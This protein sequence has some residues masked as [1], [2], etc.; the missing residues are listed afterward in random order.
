MKSLP[1]LLIFLL[2]AASPI[3]SGAPKEPALI[4]GPGTVAGVK[5]K[6]PLKNLQTKFGK[7]LK[8]EVEETGDGQFEY[9]GLRDASGE[10]LVRF[11]LLEGMVHRAEVV[12]PKVK[13][14]KG[15]GVGSSLEQLKTAYPDLK[16]QGSENEGRTSASSAAA[17]LSFLIDVNLWKEEL[18]EQE[19]KAIPPETKVLSVVVF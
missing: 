17:K 1:F 12:S 10:E 2:L 6:T 15:V 3:V 14:A 11:Y 19:L 18:T 9:Y 13:T 5:A 8:K 7:K 16:I 4:I